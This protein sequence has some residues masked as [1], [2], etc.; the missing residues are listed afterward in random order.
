MFVCFFQ[1]LPGGVVFRVSVAVPP[2]S[3]LGSNWGPSKKR[4]TEV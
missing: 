2:G 4:E 3:D 1:Q